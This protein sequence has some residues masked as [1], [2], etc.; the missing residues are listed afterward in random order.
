MPAVTQDAQW[1]ISSLT[2]CRC[3]AGTFKLMWSK[4]TKALGGWA[5]KTAEDISE[6]NGM[7]VIVSEN[8]LKEA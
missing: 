7:S 3:T 1:R 6:L 4:R 8:A 2:K 5:R